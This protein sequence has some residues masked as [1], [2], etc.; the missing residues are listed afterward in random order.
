MNNLSRGSRVLLLS[1]TLVIGL[2]LSLAM[3]AC[4]QKPHGVGNMPTCGNHSVTINANGVTPSDILVCLGDSITW[5][6]SDTSTFQVTF[7]YAPLTNQQPTPASPHPA[8]TMSFPSGVTTATGYDASIVSP[9][10][11]TN[12]CSVVAYQYCYKYN[13]TLG[14]GTAFDPHVIIMPPA[15]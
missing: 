5:T 7:S 2:T 13:V 9:T 14:N 1:T 15:N 4:A 8:R 6:A 11:G 12:N 10:S 3:G